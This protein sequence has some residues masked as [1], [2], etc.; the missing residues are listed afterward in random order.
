MVN[1]LLLMLVPIGIA[2]GVL[3]YF[4]HRVTMAEFGIQLLIPALLT[5]SGLGISYCQSTADVELLNGR[6]IQKTSERISCSHSYRCRCRTVWVGS[7][8]NRHMT[9]KCDTCYEHPYDISWYV[10]S[11]IPAVSEIDRV[12]RRGTTMPPRWGAAY[13]GEPFVTA[14]SYTNYILAN[15]DSVLLGGK[16]DIERFKD[17]L[18]KSYP[19]VYDYY[20]ANHVLTLGG[21]PLP[22]SQAWE[23][24][25]R[26]VNADLGP[27]KQVNILM[28]VVKTDDP[29]Y[30]DALKDHWVGG[31]KNDVLI[32]IGSLDG[33]RIN[34]TDVLSW[35]PN[36]LYK[37]KL[38]DAIQDIGSL[39]RR[40]AIVAQIRG[41]TLTD[42]QR[43]NMKQYEYLVRSFQPSATA[44]L[45]LFLIGTFASIG[46]AVWAVHNEIYCELERKV[47]RSW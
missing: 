38:R 42:F 23:W 25:L 5:L 11:N 33:R 14:H 47:Y 10:K 21:V 35:T 46:V 18:P 3:L 9:T 43:M 40:D 1:F 7:G 44:M 13:V 4:K 24:L 16:G 41:L 31:K 17:L 30:V 28:L 12:D 20:K 26:E 34:F 19:N 39:D 6:V 8:K 36:Q 15:P 29:S 45:V 32:V 37:V 2:I 22:E 27:Q